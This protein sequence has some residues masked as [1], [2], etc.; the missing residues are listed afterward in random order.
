MESLWSFLQQLFRRQATALNVTV[1]SSSVCSQLFPEVNHSKSKL[2]RLTNGQ[3]MPDIASVLGS[4]TY[5]GLGPLPCSDSVRTYVTINPWTVDRP[6]ARPLH[7]KDNK[8]QKN[9][10]RH[11]CLQRDSKPR[12]RCS[13]GPI[14]YAPNNTK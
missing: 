1:W 9:T 12:S 6:I 7:T 4:S 8:T 10:G 13:S 3:P 11:P 14:P 2:S 5:H